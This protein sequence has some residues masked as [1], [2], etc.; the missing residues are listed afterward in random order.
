[1]DYL[2]VSTSLSPISERSIKVLK[3]HPSNLH[4]DYSYFSVSYLFFFFYM[5]PKNTLIMQFIFSLY[6][7]FGEP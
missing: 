1:M 7:Q 4:V 3:N 2:F 5:S 6:F